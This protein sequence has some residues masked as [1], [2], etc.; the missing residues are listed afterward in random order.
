MCVCV[1]VYVYT[2]IHIN[3]HVELMSYNKVNLPL[4]EGS[5]L[6]MAINQFSKPSRLRCKDRTWANNT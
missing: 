2:N 6:N 5:I 4:R 3:T 1:Y